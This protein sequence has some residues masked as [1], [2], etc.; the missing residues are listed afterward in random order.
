MRVSLTSV[1]YTNISF[2]LLHA[3]NLNR[4]LGYKKSI[5]FLK[6]TILRL[7]LLKLHYDFINACVCEPLI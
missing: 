7:M 6:H 5:Q 3:G 1:F 4:E 2:K